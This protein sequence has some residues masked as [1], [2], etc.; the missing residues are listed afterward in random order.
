MKTAPT[1]QRITD[2]HAELQPLHL[3]LLAM[4]VGC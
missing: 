4:R 3:E 2:M 1:Q